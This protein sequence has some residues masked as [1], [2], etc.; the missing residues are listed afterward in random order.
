MDTLYHL[1]SCCLYLSAVLILPRVRFDSTDAR[2]DLVHKRDSAIGHGSSAQA[3]Y[4]R[5]KRQET[6]V[7]HEKD[8]KSHAHK[9]L[10][11]NQVPE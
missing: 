1:P 8:Q 2:Q 4:T 10:P 3:Q 7:W 11:A 5:S 9:R 6:K